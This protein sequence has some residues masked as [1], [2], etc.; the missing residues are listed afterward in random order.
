MIIGGGPVG[1]ELAGEIATDFSDKRITVVHGGERLVE[2][3]GPKA[4]DK[5]L[6]WLTSKKVDVK[7]DRTVVVD[8]MSD[9]TKSFRTSTGEMI[10]ADAHFVCTGIPLASAWLRK[11]ILD[12]NLDSHGRLM[13]DGYLRVKGRK[14]IFA[15]GDI[16]D[17]R[18]RFLTNI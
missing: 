12:S 11:T 17:I 6:K 16:T 5:A 7:L 13:V 3:M 15:I 2:F 14:N 4:S 18:V 9:E 8:D 10:S 1:V